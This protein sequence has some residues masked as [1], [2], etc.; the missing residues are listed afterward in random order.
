MKHIHQLIDQLEE[1]HYKDIAGMNY[2]IPSLYHL[3][4]KAREYITLLTS[5]FD[6]DDTTDFEQFLYYLDR[7]V[8][9]LTLLTT[10]TVDEIH[11]EWITFNEEYL[12]FKRTLGNGLI[13]IQFYHVNNHP[14][15]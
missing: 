2:D 3:K 10:Y 9:D 15:A 6:I 4:Y 7:F 5:L 1:K 12:S 11:S 8:N 14:M 13:E